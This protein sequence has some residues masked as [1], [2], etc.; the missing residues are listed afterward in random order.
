MK[1]TPTMKTSTL[2][3]ILRYVGRYPLSLIGSLLFAAISVAATL[4]IPVLF[5]DAIDCILESGIA[6]KEARLGK[7]PKARSARKSRKPPQV[8]RRT[9]RD[10]P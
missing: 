10:W 5:G 8:P 3:R 6:W 1:N 7:D 2:K 9:P 4:F